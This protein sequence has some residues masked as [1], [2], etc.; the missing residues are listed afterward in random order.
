MLRHALRIWLMHS[1]AFLAGLVV[2]G[3]VAV[4]LW[5]LVPSEGGN[6]LLLG[7]ALGVSIISVGTGY[8]I[9]LALVAA[10]LGVVPGWGFYLFGPLVVLAVMA[11]VFTAVY[12]GLLAV[13]GGSLL[14]YAL[15]YLGGG[16]A[17]HRL[18]AELGEVEDTP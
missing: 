11:L 18:V 14:G 7:T 3:V 17:L 5:F 13:G 15:L 12:S 10:L 16:A 8:A 4:G 9:Y 2:S 6:A 1:L